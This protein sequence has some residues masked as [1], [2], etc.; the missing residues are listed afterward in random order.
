MKLAQKI[1]PCLWFDHQAEEAATFYVSVFE[2]S[3]IDRISRYTEA[4]REIHGRAPGSVMAVSFFLDGQP[5]TALNGGP[6]FRLNEAVSFQVWC[7]TQRELDHYWEKLTA[8][9]DPGAQQCGWLK[10]RFGVSWQ[11]LPTILNDL[12]G[13]RDPDK[14]QKAMAALLTMKKLDIGGLKRACNE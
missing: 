4:G 2:N 7:D 1:A 14:A 10:D 9:G 5:F 3:R 12:L 11:V 13:H 6:V 8:G